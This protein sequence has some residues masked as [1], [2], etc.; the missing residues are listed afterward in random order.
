MDN[1]NP[2]S[3]IYKRS[4]VNVALIYTYPTPIYERSF[5]NVA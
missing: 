5:V 2:T 3:H 4:F 1:P